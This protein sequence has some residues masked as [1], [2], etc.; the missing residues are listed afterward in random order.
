MSSP[1]TISSSEDAP[2][3]RREF[4]A[5]QSSV[6]QSFSG[7]NDKIDRLV[8]ARQVNWTFVLGAMGLLGAG[9]GVGIKSLSDTNAHALA[10][11][12]HSHAIDDFRARLRGGETEIDALRIEQETQ[13][14]WISDVANL[15]HAYEE[16]IRNARCATCEREKR[17][18]NDL[19]FPPKD[20]WPLGQIGRANH[21]GD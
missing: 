10:I 21:P 7:L 13:N 17:P 15:S 1:D 9:L 3:K 18:A 16:V 4:D 19:R 20:Y 2:V 14:R 5:F 6:T 11:E 12:N 8:Q